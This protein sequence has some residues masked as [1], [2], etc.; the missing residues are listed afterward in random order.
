MF[1]YN[2]RTNTVNPYGFT[3]NLFQKQKNTALQ[4]ER[5]S[6]IAVSPITIDNRSQAAGTP[7]TSEGFANQV[8]VLGYTL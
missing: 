5:T 8:Q 1:R 4:T 2:P 3:E 6:S 7:N